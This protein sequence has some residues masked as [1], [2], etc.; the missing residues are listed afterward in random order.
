MSISPAQ[1]DADVETVFDALT[2]ML[3]DAGLSCDRDGEESVSFVLTTRWG[4]CQAM[5]LWRET[6]AC[7][8]FSASLDLK[9]SPARRG[10][11]CELVARVNEQL[12][13][14]HFDYWI[15]EGAL[16]FRHTLPLLDGDLPRPADVMAVVAAALDATERFLPAF[17][18][19]VWA[20]QTPEQA[21]SSAVVETM[22]EA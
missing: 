3:E 17:N 1:E 5:F 21:M 20:G 8:H 13:L 18:F 14:G 9:T 10:P 6:P 11:L 22:G 12:W 19:V 7:L 2:E 4:A 15:E 16:L